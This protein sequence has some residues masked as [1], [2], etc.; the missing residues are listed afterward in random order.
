MLWRLGCFVDLDALE[1]WRLWRSGGF[2]GL[3]AW[4]PGGFGGLKALEALEAYRL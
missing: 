2:G 4:R 1:A 3:K